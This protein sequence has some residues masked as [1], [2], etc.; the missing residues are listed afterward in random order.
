LSILGETKI[1]MGR[2]VRTVRS[3]TTNSILIAAARLAWI[4]RIAAQLVVTSVHAAL[5]TELIACSAVAIL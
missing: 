4:T 1:E 2:K 3:E 5:A